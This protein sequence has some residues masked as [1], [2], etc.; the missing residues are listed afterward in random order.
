MHHWHDAHEGHT[1]HCCV[2]IPTN[3][4]AHILGCFLTL[5]TLSNL[6]AFTGLVSVAPLISLAPLIPALLT[7]YPT[8]MFLLMV[9]HNDEDSRK[10]YAT[11][12]KFYTV[13]INVLIGIAWLGCLGFSIWFAIN[14]GFSQFIVLAIFAFF[15]FLIAIF[16]NAHFNKVVQT[17]A[18]HAH[19]DEGYVKQ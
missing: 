14:T 8:V 4:G 5:A 3:V 19:H 13:F 10:H 15:P 17:Y 7:G 2:C 1:E 6:T 18:K 16:L 9:R 11:A 12:Y